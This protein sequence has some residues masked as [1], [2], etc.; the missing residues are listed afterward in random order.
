MVKMLKTLRWHIRQE[1]GSLSPI[2]RFPAGSCK[3][4]GMYAFE[5]KNWSLWHWADKRRSA[6]YRNHCLGD[7]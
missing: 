4:L 5:R 2:E 1:S 6:I 3:M 7:V